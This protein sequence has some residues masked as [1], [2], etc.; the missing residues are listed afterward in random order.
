MSVAGLSN[1]VR[2]DFEDVLVRADEVYHRT[3]S[4]CDAIVSASASEVVGLYS[5][6]SQSAWEIRGPVAHQ[7]F[8]ERSG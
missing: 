4:P 8:R 5:E 7:L 6:D 3:Q 2:M 1:A